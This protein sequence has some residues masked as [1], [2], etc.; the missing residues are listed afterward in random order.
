MTGGTVTAAAEARLD[1]L[2]EVAHIASGGAATALSNL[3]ARTIEIAVPSAALAPLE[4]LTDAFTQADSPATGIV[5][6]VRGDLDAVVVLV[7]PPEDAAALCRLL[8]VSP[9]DELAASAL[10]EVG[11]IVGCSYIAA[12]GALAG[13]ELEP[14]PPTFLDGT[15]GGTVSAAAGVLRGD[16]ALVLLDS[17]IAI[18][19]EH[20]SFDFVF[21]PAG[22]AV[23]T[24]LRRL[25]V[26]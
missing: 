9:G 25:G 23:E 12:I 16:G 24:L 18:E 7:F 21:V 17:R 3:L 1:A 26:S 22:G 5:T 13:L 20:C 10:G 2:K 11:N 14:G 8:G 19:D 6:P 15:V 4:R